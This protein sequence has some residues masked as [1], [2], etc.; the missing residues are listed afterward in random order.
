MRM[1]LAGNCGK[2]AGGKFSREREGCQTPRRVAVNIET[3]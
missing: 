1:I 3:V 2:L